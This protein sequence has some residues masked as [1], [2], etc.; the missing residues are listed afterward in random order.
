MNKLN[1]E[2]VGELIATQRRESLELGSTRLNV[3]VQRDLDRDHTYVA[4]DNLDVRG[5]IRRWIGGLHAALYRTPLL[6]GT[7]FHV[8]APLP[9]GR[10]IGNS[11]HVDE[12]LPQRKVFVR[13]IKLNRAARNVDCVVTNAGKL[14]Y[15]C[16]WAKEDQG[17]RWF[18]IFA[19]DVYGWITLGDQTHFESRGCA[20]AYLPSTGAPVGSAKFTQIQAD[21]P[22]EYPLDP[23][24]T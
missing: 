6:P 23:F 15:E 20:G 16:V 22:N 13:T 7:P 10:K 14:R 17:P 12:V 11:V 4:F 19:L 8:T 21:V 3:R 9:S 2:K 18:C 5:A 24:G 1:D